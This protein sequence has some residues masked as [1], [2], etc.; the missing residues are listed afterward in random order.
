MRKLPGLVA[1]MFVAAA[2]GLIP[3]ASHAADHCPDMPDNHIPKVHLKELN[4]GPVKDL[5]LDYHARYYEIDVVAV[6]ATARKFIERNATRWTKPALVL[7][8]DETSLDNWPVLIADNLGFI[9]GRT[10]DAPPKGPCGFTGWILSS[11][12]KAIAPARELFDVAK[13]RNIAVIFITGRRDSLR[14]ATIKNLEAAGFTG[15]TELHTR[16]DRD[17]LPTAEA[18]KSAERLKVEAEGY[19]IIANVGDQLSDITGE[20]TGKC[21]F[22]VPNPFYFIK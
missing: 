2:L 3:L 6:F 4:I 15:W 11:S 18:Y 19:T 22:K 14:D 7:D 17:D 12:A 21:V 13:A 1:V 5:L 10:C 16:P 9:D 20:P 8:I